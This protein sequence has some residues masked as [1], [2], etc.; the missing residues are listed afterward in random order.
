MDLELCRELVRCEQQI[1]TLDERIKDKRKESRELQERILSQWLIELP[2]NVAL[3]EGPTLYTRRDLHI[4]KKKD[5]NPEYMRSVL[6]KHGFDWLVFETYSAPKLKAYIKEQMADAVEEKGH[7]G[8][9]LEHLPEEV[10]ELFDVY[11]DTKVVVLNK[12]KGQ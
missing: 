3:A 6:K 8:V 4:N 7:P 1:K 2:R 9:P 11:E 10:R 5:V 12:D